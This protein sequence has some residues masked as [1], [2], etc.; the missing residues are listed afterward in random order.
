MKRYKKIIILILIVMASLPMNTSGEIKEPPRPN[1]NKMFDAG[2]EEG[3]NGLTGLSAQEVFEKLKTAEYLL[4]T[5]LAYKAV[6]KSFV[7][8]KQEGLNLA[9]AYLRS[10]LKEVVG[11]RVV[12]RLRDFTAAKRI[13]ETFPEDAAL[14]LVPL[15]ERSDVIM[16]G[17]II[18]AIGNVAGGE[19]IKKLLM[20]GLDD[21]SVYEEEDPDALGYP[22][23]VCDLAYN[24]LVIRYNIRNVLRTISPSHRTETRD[25]HIGVLKGML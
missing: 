16:K 14:L 11:D 5:D 2:K 1:V 17:N 9:V 4:N 19:E 3:I 8:R 20:R 6:Y 21:T 18:Q 13:F 7:A 10:P 24:Q 15:Y 12:S 22:L 25:Y 23:R